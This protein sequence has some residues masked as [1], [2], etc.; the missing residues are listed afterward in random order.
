MFATVLALTALILVTPNLI[1]HPSELASLPILIVALTRDQA[2]VIVD[3]T[4]AVQAYLYDNITLDVRSLPPPANNTTIGSYAR[5]DT[6]SGQVY[7][8]ANATPLYIHARLV[9]H[10]GNFF[11]ENV[12]MNLTTDSNSNLIMVFRFPTNAGDTEITRTPPDDFRWPVPRR[13]MIE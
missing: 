6:Y 5:N 13:G 9:D 10:S 2:T 7:V 3:V 1:G 12:T 4:G 11:E 8:P